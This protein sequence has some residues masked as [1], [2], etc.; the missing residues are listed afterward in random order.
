MVP[1]AMTAPS[2]ARKRVSI[3]PE[4]DHM[5]WNIRKEDFAVNYIFGKT[6]E[7][8]GVIAGGSGK[9]VWAIWMRRYYSHPD[10]SDEGPSGGNVLYIFRLVVEGDDTTN[11]PYGDQ[12][13]PAT[14]EYVDRVAAFKAVIGA[15]RAE[16]GKWCL[17]QVQLWDPSP[18]MQGLLRQSGHTAT[19]IK[20]HTHNIA[21][22]LWFK[23][24]VN[25]AD[26][27][28]CWINEHYAWCWAVSWSCF[29][30]APPK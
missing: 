1:E 8:K 12:L 18:F 21:S 7:A 19:H 28:P 13:L 14:D 26:E 2:T 10:L 17:C 4:L 27:T 20:R 22:M 9:Q 5:L 3:L 30:W 11:Q 16:A 25:G 29:D 24:E 6:A 15:A 23:E